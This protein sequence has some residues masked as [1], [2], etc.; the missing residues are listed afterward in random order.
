MIF[1]DINRTPTPTGSEARTRRR[2]SRRSAGRDEEGLAR[3]RRRSTFSEASRLSSAERPRSDGSTKAWL[4][5]LALL[6]VAAVG[7]AAYLQRERGSKVL[8]PGTA[9]SSQLFPFVDPVLAPLETGNGGFDATNLA[10]VSE[11]FSAARTAVSLDD[12]EIY[13]VAGTLAGILQEATIDRDRHL[14]RLAGLGSVV[15][16]TSDGGS[17]V[18]SVDDKARRHHELAVAVSWQRNSGAYRNRVEE[19][20]YRLLR[21]EQGRFRLGSAPQSM[22][23]ELPTP[24]PSNE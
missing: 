18:P 8:L 20:W 4:T 12:R 23:P 24:T 1:D 7:F 11:G 17:S 22:M 14:Q 19:L 5:V 10:A 3:R 2:S 6:V 15:Q 13:S 21:L 9:P 16:G